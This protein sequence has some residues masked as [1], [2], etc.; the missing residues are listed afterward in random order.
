MTRRILAIVFAA[1]AGLLLLGTQSPK[2]SAQC[3][4]VATCGL[5]IFSPGPQ[6]SKTPKD[7]HHGNNNAPSPTAAAS[8]T[9]QA[10]SLREAATPSPNKQPDSGFAESKTVN[11]SD[12][13]NAAAF[14]TSTIP[15]NND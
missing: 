2:A 12:G 14:Q 3:V 9:L 8:E 1:A 5:S 11:Q 15:R 6:P 4:P 10:L 7:E 13:N